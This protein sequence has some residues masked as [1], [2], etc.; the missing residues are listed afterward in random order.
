MAN[1]L[2]SLFKVDVL[3]Q[4]VELD[5]NLLAMKSAFLSK[6]FENFINIIPGAGQSYNLMQVTEEGI[7]C[8]T[9]QLQCLNFTAVQC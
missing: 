1:V 6:T 2:A 5:K 8:S 9:L 4:L 3:S 7:Y